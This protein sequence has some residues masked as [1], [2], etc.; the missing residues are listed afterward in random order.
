MGEILAQWVS[1]ADRFYQRTEIYGEAWSK[2][3]SSFEKF[4]PAPYGGP[5]LVVHDNSEIH[6]HQVLLLLLLVTLFFSVFLSTRH[7][8]TTKS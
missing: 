8:Q 1:V 7:L 4:T 5:I 3:L 6:I 2:Q